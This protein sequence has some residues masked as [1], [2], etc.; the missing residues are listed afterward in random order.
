MS[1]KTNSDIPR[2]YLFDRVVIG[3]CLLMVLLIGVWGR[4]FGQYLSSMLFYAGMAAVAA[5]I[6]RCV[7]P[8][9]NRWLAFVRLGYP[10]VMFTFFYWQTGH[11]MFLFFNGFF[12]WQLVT[13][14]HMIFGGDPS[15]Y[16]DQHLLNVWLN[17]VL[18]FCYFAYYPMLPA[19][20]LAVFLKKDDNVLKEFLAVT[21]LTFFAS[22]LLFALYPV[23]GPRWHFAQEYTNAI[24]GP[25]FRQLVNLVIANGA[26][27]GGAMPSS[28][29]GVAFVIMVFCFRYYRRWGWILLPVVLGLAAG[30]VWGRFHYVSDVVVGVAI[31][32]LALLWVWSRPD[33]APSHPEPSLP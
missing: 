25:V 13:F 6:T 9:K 29:T 20:V 18:S 22:Y 11:L 33:T 12:D 5:T 21:C 3:Y 27:H 26:V 17:E 16:I 1:L 24:D 32:A 4:P 31:A 10:A 30:T 28:H 2:L 14:E 7:D 19:F 15:L 8:T 23:E